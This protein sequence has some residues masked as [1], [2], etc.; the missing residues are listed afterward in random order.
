MSEYQKQ[1]KNIKNIYG[2]ANNASQSTQ[3]LKVPKLKL[4][5]DLNAQGTESAGQAALTALPM[6]TKATKKQ[7]LRMHGAIKQSQINSGRVVKNNQI[8]AYK[9]AGASSNEP[10]KRSSSN[11]LVK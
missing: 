11:K 4:K 9:P 10:P 3:M 1:Q 6:N 2:G 5:A 8:Q 7:T